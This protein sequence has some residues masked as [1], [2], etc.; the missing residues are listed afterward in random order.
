MDIIAPVVREAGGPFRIES[1]ELEGPRADELLVE[2]RATGICH[3]DLGVRDQSIPATLPSVLGHEGAG[4]VR[5]VGT[6]VSGFAAGDHVVMSHTYCGKCADCLAGN[7]SY[8]ARA[9]TAVYKGLRADGSCTLHDADG[10]PVHTFNQGSFGTATLIPAHLAVKVAEDLPFELIAPLGCG[11]MTGA[12]AVINELK[13]AVGSSIAVFGAGGVGLGAIAA[14]ALVGCSTIIAIDV[15]RSRL[16]LAM[17]MGATHVVDASAQDAVE[18]V[19]AVSGG[20][21]QFSVE[22]SGAQVCGPRAVACLARLGSAALVGAPGRGAELGLDWTDVLANGKGVRGV[23]MGWSNPMSF[24][25]YM[26]EHW[27]AGRFP[28]DKMITV[29]DFA[30]FTDAV[31]AMESGE[32]VKPVIRFP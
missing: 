20:G 15:R 21:A 24:I 8:C 32:V 5:A 4:I 12:G 11:V 6:E 1:L 19:R 9:V 31:E 29:F 28:F 3:T 16:E 17:Q 30:D 25:P 22:A 18:A 14:A 10:R 7:V 23:I 13:P 26:I 2:L 27:Q